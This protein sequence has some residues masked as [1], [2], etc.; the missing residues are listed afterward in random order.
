VIKDSCK[1]GGV[2]WGGGKGGGAR[3]LDLGGG[4]SVKQ[5]ENEDNLCRGGKKKEGGCGGQ[6]CGEPLPKWRAFQIADQAAMCR[7]HQKKKKKNVAEGKRK[8]MPGHDWGGN[9]SSE[10]KKKK[11]RGRC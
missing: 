3:H 11:K 8:N 6:Q 5:R 1:G 4:F 7:S 2:F 9:P 10:I